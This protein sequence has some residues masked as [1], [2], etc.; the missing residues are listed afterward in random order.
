MNDEQTSKLEDIL[1]RYLTFYCNLAETIVHELKQPK[2]NSN[3]NKSW[4]N[5]PIP[6]KQNSVYFEIFDDVYVKLNINFY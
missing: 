3:N 4:L 1:L 6:Y 5:D 2:E